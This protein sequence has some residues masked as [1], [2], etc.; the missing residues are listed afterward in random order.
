MFTPNFD[1]KTIQQNVQQQTASAIEWG[2]R[3]IDWQIN[4]A[5][6]VRSHAD[7]QTAAAWDLALNATKSTIKANKDLQSAMLATL[8]PKTDEA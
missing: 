5:D 6:I 8:T 2:T 7:K 3:L 4:Q 1:P